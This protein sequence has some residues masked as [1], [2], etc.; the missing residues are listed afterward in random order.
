MKPLIVATRCCNVL[1][2]RRQCDQVVRAV[3]L[4]SGDPGFKTRSD[5][6]LNLTL[7]VPGSTGC[8][9]PSERISSFVDTL[10]QPIAQKQQSFIKDTTDFIETKIGKDTILVSMEVSSLYTNIPQEEGVNIVYEAYAKFHNHN[11]PIQTLFLRQML[12]L[13]LN[14]NS[15]QFNGDNY[16]QTH[17]TAM[18]TKM[19]VSFANIFMALI[20][21]S[22]IQQNDTKPRI[23]KRYIDDI[24]SFW[25]SNKNTVD[26]FVIQA[27]KFHPT[28]KFTA[29]ISENEITF[30]DTEVFKGERFKNESILDIRTHYKPTETFQY[31][32]YNSC[33][34][35]GVKNGN[36][37]IKGEAMRLLRTNSSKTT[38]EENLEKFKRAA[39]LAPS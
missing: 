23:W 6:S 32:H 9:G 34:P 1:H 14:E 33:H 5:H 21:T 19:A 24:F 12:G 38:F 8:D 27:N 3:A 7:V 25:N 16:L 17:G 35:P 30:L 2:C 10:L 31:T 4:R 11:P 22:L 28:I 15:F 20:E 36:G 37:F 18:G 39:I 26:L 13:I 29:E